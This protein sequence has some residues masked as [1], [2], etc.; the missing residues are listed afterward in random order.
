MEPA[1]VS[2][3]YTPHSRRG[4]TGV[5][6]AATGIAVAVAGAI[7]MSRL[8][9]GVYT[10]P[11][12]CPGGPCIYAAPHY[13]PYIPTFLIAV[14][15][16]AAIAPLLAVLLPRF[17]WAGALCTLVGVGLPGAVW[18]TTA[19]N[20]PYPVSPAIVIPLSWMLIA[21]AAITAVGLLLLTP[22]RIVV[23]ATESPPATSNGV[24]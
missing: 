17:W 8:Q 12:A 4:L 9:F 15:L 10:M 23:L 16:G 13:Y 11:G 24:V 2:L 21:G 6:V 14:V 1:P 22:P 7:G 19:L 5:G 3:P 18:L 20:P